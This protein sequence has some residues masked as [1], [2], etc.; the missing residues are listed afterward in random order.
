[1]GSVTPGTVTPKGGTEEKELCSPPGSAQVLTENRPPPLA[2][3]GAAAAAEAAAAVQARS[4]F[5]SSV[6]Y[7]ASSSGSMMAPLQEQSVSSVGDPWW[8]ERDSTSSSMFSTSSPTARFTPV[9]PGHEAPQGSLPTPAQAPQKRVQE[10][11]VCVEI[12]P[13][14]GHAHSSCHPA[15]KATSYLATMA[16]NQNNSTQQQMSM[17]DTAPM[18]VA[19]SDTGGQMCSDQQWNSGYSATA[20]QPGQAVHGWGAVA[21]PDMHCYAQHWGQWN[22]GSMY[23]GVEG[24]MLGSCDPYGRPMCGT[25]IMS[26]D[27][28]LIVRDPDQCPSNPANA[29]SPTA[30][31]PSSAI[32]NSSAAAT[33]GFEQAGPGVVRYQVFGSSACAPVV[34]PVD[35]VATYPAE[36][37][38][39]G[40][41]P[42][43]RSDSAPLLQGCGGLPA[44]AGFPGG[45]DASGQRM[46][47]ESSSAL[48]LPR[49]STPTTSPSEPKPVPQAHSAAGVALVA[50]VANAVAQRAK[51]DQP[52]AKTSS[53]PNTSGSGTG[54][55]MPKYRVGMRQGSTPQAAS[56]QTT[57]HQAAATSSSDLTSKPLSSSARFQAILNRSR[58]DSLSAST[59]HSSQSR[60]NSGT[61]P[62]GPCSQSRVSREN[63]TAAGNYT[64]SLK[65]KHGNESSKTSRASVLTSYS[66]GHTTEA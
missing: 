24:P 10:V 57:S 7:Q 8:K 25:G 2:A 12:A 65:T 28:P 37:P 56:K 30:G 54:R 32:V 9:E 47:T 3:A 52:A 33:F 55:V 31:S 53:G 66:Q 61:S 15:Q 5:L 62:S 41:E 50:D 58:G 42:R 51:P 22:A 17:P 13:A 40:P 64:L 23:T 16:H 20:P 39:I 63:A 46:P 19:H 48:Q 45:T 6:S 43:A 38:V 27:F 59:G 49:T 18:S 60:V 34:A 14:P 26:M 21:A 11:E 29:G 1:V 35:S 44:S 36:G 4:K